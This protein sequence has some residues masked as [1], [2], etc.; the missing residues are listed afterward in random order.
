M[1]TITMMNIA[2]ICNKIIEFSFYS[3]FFFVPLAFAS[4][5]FELFEFNKMW[6]T[7]GL[8]I[9]IAA[10]WIAKMI[11][12][13]RILLCRTPLDIP[14][15]LFLTSQIISTIFSWDPHV[16]IW[17]YYSRFNGGLLSMISYVFLYYA[18][19]SNFRNEQARGD[20][21]GGVQRSASSF[22]LERL[23]GAPLDERAAGPRTQNNID[24]YVIEVNARLSRSSALASK[25][26]GYPLAYVA[27]KLALGKNLTEIKN[28]VTRVTQVCFEPALDYI[29]V[30]IPRWDI[31]KFKGAEEKIGSSMKSVGEVMGIG[32][33]FEEAYQKAIRML[34]LDFE[35][36]TS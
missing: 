27:A 5:T 19:V 35:G 24:Y 20:A 4:D 3:L 33:M 26:T 2:N 8:T 34:D 22:E 1:T 11:L 21:S 36:A 6:L 17:G 30:K 28:K 23:E 32:R 16:S 12:Q 25:A 14:I 10:S 7:Y 18:F 15:A 9:I 29:V 31:E 13:R